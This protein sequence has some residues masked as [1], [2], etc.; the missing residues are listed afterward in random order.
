MAWWHGSN[1][2]SMAGVA[3]PCER[4]SL[5]QQ[6]PE[7]S[8]SSSYMPLG[9]RSFLLC[10]ATRRAHLCRSLRIIFPITSDERRL[11]ERSA[12]CEGRVLHRPLSS[13]HSRTPRAYLELFAASFAPCVYST[14][15]WV[16]RRTYYFELIIS[17]QNAKKCSCG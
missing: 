7:A 11:R 2:V 15:G 16:C 5:R 10:A 13:W 9:A 8:E 6:L 17:F 4:G 12:S 14:T 3:L 1:V